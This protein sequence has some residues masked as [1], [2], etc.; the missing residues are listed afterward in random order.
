VSIGTD[1]QD[2]DVRVDDILHGRI[3]SHC[4]AL[5][6]PTTYKAATKLPLTRLTEW[7]FY[8][9]AQISAPVSFM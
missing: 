8:Q 2:S 5:V 1:V 9:V 3:P 7:R 6:S 4:T